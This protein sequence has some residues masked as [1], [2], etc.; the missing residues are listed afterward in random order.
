MIQTKHQKLTFLASA[1]GGVKLQALQECNLRP[2]TLPQLQTTG[3]GS[4]T[5]RTNVQA[6]V[7]DSVF[8]VALRRN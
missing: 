2:N 8:S 1:T 6:V 3:V 7:V 5:Q 4:K